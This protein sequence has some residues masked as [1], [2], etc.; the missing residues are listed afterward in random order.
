M[1]GRTVRTV[2]AVG[3][4]IKWGTLGATLFFVTIVSIG[5]AVHVVTF[6]VRRQRRW[7]M[8]RGFNPHAHLE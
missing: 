8:S 6:L 7:R 5:Q 3:R 4:A 1:A 2:N